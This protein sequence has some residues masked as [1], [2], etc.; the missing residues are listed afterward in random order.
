MM[1]TKPQI[2]VVL[3][4]FQQEA[5][6]SRTLTTLL[7][8][9]DETNLTSLF[10]ILLY[11]NSPIQSAIPDN[12]PSSFY[13]IHDPANGG[14]FRAYTTALHLA[15]KERIEW[16]LLLDQDTVLDTSYIKALWSNLSKAA[17]NE[18]C[19]AL[20]PKLLSEKKIISP[21]RVLW[22]GHL[23]PV[24]KTL[25]GF[26]SYEIMALNSGTL[27]RVSAIHEVGGFK[28]EFWLDYLDHWLF[29]RLHRAHFLIYVLDI[30]LMHELSVKNMRKMSVARYKNILKSEG[31]FF[32]CCKS[33]SENFAYRFTLLMRLFKI[34]AIPDRHRFLLPLI[35]H[36]KGQ[37]N[38]K[39]HLPPSD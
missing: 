11:D 18:R 9:L 25:V 21:A 26:P 16:L 6:S 36:I 37:I 29:N 28:P 8:S 34:V 30:M 2:L 4:L 27:L 32:K 31:E 7:R 35:K 13:F 5:F 15:E 22:G 10:R 23:L 39:T 12:L 14:L 20:V 1:D 3:V 17:K 19:A 38:K 33:R 24:K